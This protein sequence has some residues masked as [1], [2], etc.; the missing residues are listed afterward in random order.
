MSPGISIAVLNSSGGLLGGHPVVF[1]PL[2]EGEEKM[3]RTRLGA[4][5]L[6]AAV[7]LLLP[8]V[9]LAQRNR[10]GGGRWEGGNW[11]GRSWD[12]G[13]GGRTGFYFGY[14]SPY[15]TS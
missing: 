8:S 6:A 10:G 13:W 5:A 14:G 4:L 11:S 7:V 2:R 15:G 12:G 3:N 1:L 9:S